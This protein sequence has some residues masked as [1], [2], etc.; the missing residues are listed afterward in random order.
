MSQDS[1]SEKVVKICDFILN[2]ANQKADEVIRRAE[3]EARLLKLQ[4]V[5]KELDRMAETFRKKE[6]DVRQKTR[7]ALSSA[8]NEAR[9]QGLNARDEALVAVVKDVKETLFALTKEKGKY[10]HVLS[11]LIVEAVLELKE[12]PVF[13]VCREEDTRLVK[14]A[15]RGARKSLGDVDVSVS[16]KEHL[17][18]APATVSDIGC[19]GGIVATNS[20][21]L[22]RVNNTLDRRVELAVSAL[23][24]ELRDTLFT[25]EAEVACAALN[26]SAEMHFD[27]EADPEE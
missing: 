3:E 5:D 17:A 23:L 14:W 12:S 10:T 26:E 4:E 6:V 7:I 11:Q 27:A 24:P 25:P 9:L 19:L 16:T 1:V 21:G 20:S 2:Q 13:I 15:L 18:A 22:I 8:L